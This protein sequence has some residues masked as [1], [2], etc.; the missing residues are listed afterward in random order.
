MRILI[1]ED[2]IT[3]AD[4]LSQGLKENYFIPEVA[5][6]GQDGLHLASSN[7]YAAIILDVMLPIIDGWSLIKMIREK[8]LNTPILFLTAKDMVDNRVKGLE[9]GADDYLIKPFAFSELLARIRSLLRRK[10]PQ[11]PDVSQVADLKID[12]QAHTV[13]RANEYINLTA[14][15]FMLLSLLINKKGEVLSRTYIAEKVWDINFDSDT[16]TIDVAI[17]RLREKMDKHF[18]KK[19]IHCIRG[20]GYV[21][22]AR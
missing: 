14:K 22:E 21:L 7:N 17:N 1:I 4:Y 13:M 9:L 19:L 20:V 10:Q 15:E 18:D 3:T 2:N 12:M 8:D 11:S 5:Y 16:N 6:N